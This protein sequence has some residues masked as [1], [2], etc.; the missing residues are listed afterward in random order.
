MVLYNLINQ[1][2]RKLHQH[3]NIKKNLTTIFQKHIPLILSVVKKTF[4]SLHDLVC[5]DKRVVVV[6]GLGG[7]GKTT[8]VQAYVHQY[9]DNYAHNYVILPK[10][11]DIKNDLIEMLRAIK[12]S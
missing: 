11:K 6:N 4:I 5:N 8:L 9:Y 1:Q 2:L 10:R 7:I 3:Q 12:K